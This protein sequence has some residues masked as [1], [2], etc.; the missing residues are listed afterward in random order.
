LP[1]KN[2]TELNRNRSVWPGFGSVSVFFSKKK[3]FNLVTFFDKNRTEPKM[4]T[5]ISH[6]SLFGGKTARAWGLID[7]TLWLIFKLITRNLG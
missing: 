2:R 7:T 4:I 1:L 5:P 6:H 3:N